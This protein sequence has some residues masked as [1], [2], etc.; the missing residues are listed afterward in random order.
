MTGRGREYAVALFEL[1]AEDGNARE[2][3]EGLELVEK[4]LKEAPESVDFFSSPA[5]SRSEKEDVVEAC[6]RGRVCDTVLSFFALLCDKRRVSELE[7]IRREYELLFRESI[8]ES[9][10]SVVSAAPLSEEEKARLVERLEKRSGRRVLAEYRVDPALI[11]G[12][13][14]EMDGVRMDGSLRTR[15]RDVRESMEA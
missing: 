10:A 15:L 14:V 8:R 9:H 11:G 3:S 5:V 1:A 13:I 2:V 4:V 12:L 6:F 7:E